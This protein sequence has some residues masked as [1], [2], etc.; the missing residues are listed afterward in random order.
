[1]GNMGYCRMQNTV[2]D[3]A[4]CVQ[5]LCDIGSRADL[6]QAERQAA[7]RMFELCDEFRNYWEQTPDGD[8]EE[9]DEDA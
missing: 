1:M 6:S 3:L 8:D 4:D 7:E 5:A 2:N 9:D